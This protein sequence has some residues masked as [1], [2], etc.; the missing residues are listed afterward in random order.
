MSPLENF[1]DVQT[2]DCSLV[3]SVGLLSLIKANPNQREIA[4]AQETK[5]VP[6][7]AAIN[8]FFAERK[9]SFFHLKTSSLLSFSAFL[10]SLEPI[11]C[12]C[13]CDQM[14]R[15]FFNFWPFTSTKICP[16]MSL[17]T[18]CNLPYKKYPAQNLH[19]YL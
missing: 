8:L 12:C 18:L 1:Y 10:F 13:Q 4:S 3:D 14:V 7:D 5:C 11:F 15:L 19:K 9:K 16:L 17:C 6:K 2:V